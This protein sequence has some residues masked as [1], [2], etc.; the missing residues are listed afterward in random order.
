MK[1]RKERNINQH[2]NSKLQRIS[3]LKKKLQRRNWNNSY[4]E[5]NWENENMSAILA[6]RV[7]ER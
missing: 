2:I 1:H 4:K 5:R 3:F 6:K 7:K